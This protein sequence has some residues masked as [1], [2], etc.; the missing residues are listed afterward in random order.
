MFLIWEL[1]LAS[2]IASVSIR[3]PWL[4]IDA[5]T[6]QLGEV[7]MRLREGGASI[8]ILPKSLHMACDV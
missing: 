6:L 5:A 4:G 8:N 3:M 2:C 7:A 1:A